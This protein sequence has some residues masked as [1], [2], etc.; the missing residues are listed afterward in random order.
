ML[1]SCELYDPLRLWEKYKDSLER[2]LQDSARLLIDE[3]YN[4]SFIFIKYELLAQAEP[5][6]VQ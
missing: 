6:L 1:I 5:N 4:R 3:V 2:R